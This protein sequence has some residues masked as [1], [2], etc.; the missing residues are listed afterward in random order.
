LDDRLNR[1]LDRLREALVRDRGRAPFAPFV[2][3]LEGR[4]CGAFEVRNAM[5]EVRRMQE[6]LLPL[7][8]PL[9]RAFAHLAPTENLPVD[10][11]TH[12]LTLWAP[13]ELIELQVGYRWHGFNGKRMR[14]WDERVVVFAEDGGDPLAL[15]LDEDDGPV[16]LSRRGEG[17]HAFFEAAPGLADFYECVALWLETGEARGL[18]AALE[19]RYGPA[20]ERLWIWRELVS[21]VDARR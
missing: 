8:A 2:S 12:T 20:A 3:A 13:H 18:A 19:A 9:I 10:L 11:G 6:A 5:G 16:W 4:L 17:R 7:P 14:E 1:S 15:R 21:R